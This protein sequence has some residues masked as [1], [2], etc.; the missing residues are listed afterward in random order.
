MQYCR[1]VPVTLTAAS[2][3]SLIRSNSDLTCESKQGF[4]DVSSWGKKETHCSRFAQGQPA[5]AAVPAVTVVAPSFMSATWTLQGRHIPPATPL[6]SKAPTSSLCPTASIPM[7]SKLSHPLPTPSW[8]YFC[9]ALRKYRCQV[10]AACAVS[11]EGEKAGS[12]TAHCAGTLGIRLNS[13]GPHHQPT[14]AEPPL[15]WHEEAVSIGGSEVI[16]VSPVTRKSPFSH[17][18][19]RWVS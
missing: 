4:E 14:A 16:P 2:A 15:C 10:S 5:S 8:S 6:L 7:P 17:F 9:T 19:M 3:H 18:T 12:S 11:K 1:L 13:T